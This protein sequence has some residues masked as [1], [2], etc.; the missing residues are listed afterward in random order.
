MGLK[1]AAVLRHAQVSRA[2]FYQHFEGMEDCF[3]QSYREHADRLMLEVRAAVKGAHQAEFAMLDVLARMTVEHGGI[4]QLV[5][6]EGL[7]AGPKLMVERERLILGLCR[8]VEESQASREL[9][10]PMPLLVGGVFRFLSQRLGAGEGMDSARWSI[11][12]WAE[13]FVARPHSTSW[14]A[15]F[16]PVLPEHDERKAAGDV[17][18]R[19]PADQREAMIRATAMM[20]REK[21]YRAITVGDIAR[22]AGVSRRTFYNTFDTK[23]DAGIAAYEHAFQATVAACTPAF[24]GSGTWPDRVWEG[25]TAFTRFFSE[26]PL[27]AYIGFVE[28]YAIG[29]RFVPRVHDMQLAFTLFLEDGYRQRPEAQLLSRA[30]SDLTAATIFEAGFQATLRGVALQMRNTQPLAVYLALTP[31]VGRDAAGEFVRR[32]L[33]AGRS[34]GV[35]GG[36]CQ[37]ALP[38]AGPS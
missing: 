17:G 22:T 12:E 27:F 20:M 16:A 14:S 23:E 8:A 24:F 19:R 31:F 38:S 32:K 11:R 35:Q 7:A 36:R 28:C 25:A 29:T 4:A 33:T 15:A 30:C 1:V 13:T 10:L 6:R 26:E 2:S 9:D 21:G 3:W 18:W 34:K 5:M 37:G